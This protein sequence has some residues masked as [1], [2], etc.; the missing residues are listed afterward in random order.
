MLLWITLL[1][2]LCNSHSYLI[3]I[4]RKGHQKASSSKWREIT[5]NIG[6]M[7]E[8]QIGILIVYPAADSLLTE[9]AKWKS[10]SIE[11]YM[12]TLLM[13][14]ILFDRNRNRIRRDHSFSVFKW[15]LMWINTKNDIISA[16]LLITVEALKRHAWI[17][18]WSQLLCLV[19]FD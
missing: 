8:D 2:T 17:V 9:Q 11:K 1:F 10:S 3:L 18:Y 13:R 5:C 15:F 12:K 4:W 7:N 16:T 6:R 14:H 19:W